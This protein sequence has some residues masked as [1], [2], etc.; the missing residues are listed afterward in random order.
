MKGCSCKSGCDT[1]RCGCWEN[2][3]ACGPGCRC[4]NCKNTEN[5]QKE[6]VAEMQD[7][8]AHYNTLQC[9]NGERFWTTRV[10]FSMAVRVVIAVKTMRVTIVAVAAAVMTEKV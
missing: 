5:Q 2:G 4:V 7:R 3:E 10:N 1:K 8:E 6:G 9:N